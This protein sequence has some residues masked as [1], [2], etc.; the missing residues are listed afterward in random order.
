MS[1]KGKGRVALVTGAA[2]GIGL[3]AARALAQG[4]EA[5]RTS[6]PC[7]GIRQTAHPCTS[8][9][10]R[11]PEPYRHPHVSAPSISPVSNTTAT[12]SKT[13]PCGG[14]KKKGSSNK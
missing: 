6:S 12:L 1:L 11:T 4:S 13:L 7:C 3:A 2:R 9:S 8:A 5:Y 14:G 10:R